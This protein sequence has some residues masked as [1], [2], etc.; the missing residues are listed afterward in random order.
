VRDVE[1]ASRSW[2]SGSPGQVGDGIDFGIE[3]RFEAGSELAV[4]DSALEQE[5]GAPAGPPHLLRFVHAAVDQEVGGPFRDRRADPQAGTMALGIVDQPGALAG[6]I[7]V[8]L[9]QRQPA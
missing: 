9:A 4:E 6:Q 3:Q 2:G 5:I 7:A 8:D 1:G